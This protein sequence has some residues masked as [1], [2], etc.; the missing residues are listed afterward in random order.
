MSEFNTNSNKPD[1]KI[2]HN[3]KESTSSL[4]LVNSSSTTLTNTT[5][6]NSSSSAID[7]SSTYG[8]AKYII[9]SNTSEKESTNPYTTINIP[10]NDNKNDDTKSI[11]KKGKKHSILCKVFTIIMIIILSLILVMVVA[12]FIYTSIYYHASNNTL[13]FLENTSDVKISKINTGYYFDGP[14][15]DKALIFYPGGKVEETAYSDILY[16]IAKKG[17]DCYLVK[18]PFRLA[19]FNKNKANSI[20][21]EN[22]NLYKK[23]YIGGHSL[24]GAMAASYASDHEKDLDGLVLLA[25][26]SINKLPEDMKVISFLGS[27]DKVLKWDTYK[28]NI[29]NLPSNYT[30]III[31]GG[32]HGQFGDYGIQKGDGKADISVTEQHKQIV[33]G[34]FKIF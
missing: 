21:K 15:N 1:N 34:I 11:K 6:T 24:G 22:K 12:F 8:I 32:N 18:M 23:W 29:K 9:A 13:K 27:N 30:E 19:I 14:S 2:F 4:E 3:A 26:Y 17:I 20:I 33:E 28:E 10:E 25:A 31:K 16:E 5:S 7:S